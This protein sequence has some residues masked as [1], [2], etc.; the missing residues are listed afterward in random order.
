MTKEQLNRYAQCFE[1]TNGTQ[2]KVLVDATIEAVEDNLDQESLIRGLKKLDTY[3]FLACI[4]AALEGRL[5]EFNYTDLTNLTSS[6]H[7]M[8]ALCCLLK[9]KVDGNV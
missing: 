6:E 9:D 8:I 3:D 7:Q 1:S 5:E 4:E 2:G